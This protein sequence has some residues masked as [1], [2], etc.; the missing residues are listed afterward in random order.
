MVLCKGF[1]SLHCVDGSCPVALSREVDF[2]LYFGV[3]SCD[4]CYYH[5]FE[6]SDCIFY[7]T[8]YCYKVS[9]DRKYKNY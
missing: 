7:G 6:C 1:V 4:N 8:E 9:F 2:D 3:Y 5:T